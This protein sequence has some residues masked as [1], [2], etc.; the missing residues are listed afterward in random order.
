MS[1]SITVKLSTG[2]EIEMQ[3]KRFKTGKTGWYQGE[4]ITIDGKRYKLNFMIY[5]DK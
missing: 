4:K 5:E 1:G 3:V 2:Q